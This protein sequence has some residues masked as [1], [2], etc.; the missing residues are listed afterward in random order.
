MT[1]KHRFFLAASLFLVG[2]LATRAEVTA[3]EIHLVCGNGFEG[4]ASGIPE[5]QTEETAVYFL[6]CP[7]DNGC[8]TKIWKGSGLVM[9]EILQQGEAI[10]VW[11]A[12]VDVSQ[13]TDA[14]MPRIQEE[15]ESPEG[16][17]VPEVW[18][19]LLEMGFRPASDAMT[20][21]NYNMQG[22]EFTIRAQEKQEGRAP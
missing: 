10:T 22:Y 21:L 15:M 9:T 11:M 20:C 14:D 16:Y 3:I 4:T 8:H 12:E 19:K 5:G 13:A 17:L 18:H 7:V 6:T 2:S 1:T